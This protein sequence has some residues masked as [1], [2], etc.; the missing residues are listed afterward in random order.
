MTS[1][2]QAAEE[3]IFV[4]L[5]ERLEDFSGA[6][7]ATCLIIGSA[8]QGGWSGHLLQGIVILL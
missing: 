6:S 2:V 7:L 5:G 1:E 3:T 8:Y 4:I